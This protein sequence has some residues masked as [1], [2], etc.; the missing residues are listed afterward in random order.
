MVIFH[1]WCFWKLIVMHLLLTKAS[2]SPNMKDSLSFNL[3][4]N[5]YLSHKSKLPRSFFFIDMSNCTLIV[6]VAS[7]TWQ[8][9]HNL[10]LGIWN[11][12][13]PWNR[14][15]PKLAHIVMPQSYW[16]ET[17]DRRW[18]QNFDA[19]SQGV[20]VL[21]HKIFGKPQIYPL[22]DSVAQYRSPIW[23]SGAGDKTWSK[24]TPLLGSF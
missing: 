15:S 21:S 8:N 18:V 11:F 5:W 23:T 17:G 16:G 24:F 3:L 1:F 9:K 7:P 12:Q 20:I 14:D 22:K 10:A 2:H 4:D 13:S 19:L 6:D